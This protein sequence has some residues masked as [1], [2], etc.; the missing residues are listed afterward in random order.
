VAWSTGESACSRRFKVKRFAVGGA[1]V[2]PEE[3][4]SNITNI[5]WADSTVLHAID[6]ET[7]RGAIGITSEGAGSIQNVSYVNITIESVV[8]PEHYPIRIDN[9]FP[10][11][12]VTTGPISNLLFSNITVLECE[13]CTVFLQGL[14]DDSL[15]SNISLANVSSRNTFELFGFGDGRLRSSRDCY[16]RGM[17]HSGFPR[18][19]TWLLV[20]NEE[21]KMFEMHRCLLLSIYG[22]F[23][24]L[25]MP[26]ASSSNF[27][28]SWNPLRH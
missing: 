12:G 15:L 7:N 17:K 6:P 21:S 22:R 20:V 24:H 26:A 27:Q 19:N 14:S 28:S 11:P 3:V 9:A 18:S 25:L 16:H 2:I 23:N 5:V 13:L 8:G 4:E 10:D 1:F